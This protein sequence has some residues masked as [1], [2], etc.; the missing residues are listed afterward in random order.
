MCS[1]VHDIFASYFTLPILDTSV[2][3]VDLSYGSG[4]CCT[5][6]DMHYK[7]CYKHM[8]LRCTEGASKMIEVFFARFGFQKVY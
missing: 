1:I 4:I 2:L 5:L 7:C 3:Y 8:P 6:L